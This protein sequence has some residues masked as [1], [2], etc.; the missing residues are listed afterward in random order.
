MV[1][2]DR[3]PTRQRVVTEAM[4]LFG[5]QGYAATSIAQIESAAGLRPG[6]GG[7][8][9]HFASKRE[10]LEQGVREQLASRRDLIAFVTEPVRLDELPLRERLT[11]VAKAGLARLDR[12]RDL[13]RLVLRDL[14]SFPEL[15]ELVRADEMKGIQAVV[16]EWLRRQAQLAQDGVDWDALAAALMGAVSHWWML[17]DAMGEHPSGLEEDRYLAAI[18]DLVASRLER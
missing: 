4:R 9:R 7:L 11:A 15:L 16:S 1:T 5:E 17:R 14:R 12:E 13:N 6:S 18:A 10:L 8:Y 3:I 2:V